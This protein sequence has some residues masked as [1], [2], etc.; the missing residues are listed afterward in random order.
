M[1]IP[2]VKPIKIKEFEVKQSKYDRVCK[3]P[4][5]SV[6]LGPSGSGKTVLL[7]NMILD[8]Y[9]DCFS[10]IYIFS[11]SIEVDASWLPVKDYI[12]KHMKVEHTD[13]EPIY[14]DHYNP[15]DLHN[16]IE[17][18]HKI[19][20]YMKKSNSKKLFQ[21][22]I[23]VDDFADSAEF[24]R[25]SKLLHSLFTRGRHNSISTIVA[26]QKFTAIHPIV[27]VNA[28]SLFVYRLRNYRDLEA[29]IE[30]VSAVTDKKTLMDIYN[31]ATSEPYS[32]LCVRLTAKDKNDMFYIRFDKRITIVE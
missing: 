11:P 30:E 32:F 25:Q 18:Q 24:T 26:T 16:I 13:E 17:T 27:R 8:I 2:S 22:L 29:F 5:R 9:R 7:Q 3:L 1:S 12:S 6:L 23:I 20:D 21:I 15:Q 10:R 19:T 14:F 4:M 28:T 31:L